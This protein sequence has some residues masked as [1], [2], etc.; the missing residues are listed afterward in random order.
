[1]DESDI[2]DGINLLVPNL[3][4]GGEEGAPGSVRS[5]RDF[6][7]LVAKLPTDRQP[8]LQNLPPLD[9]AL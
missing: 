8:R 3:A 5:I 2:S 9:I 1:M 4:A 6:G 7:L